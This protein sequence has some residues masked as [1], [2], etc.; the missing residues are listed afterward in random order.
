MLASEAAP[1]DT[2]ANM[3]QSVSVMG[4]AGPSPFRP[5]NSRTANRPP[6]LIPRARQQ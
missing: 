3:A 6:T 4:N 2:P 5:S 1:Y